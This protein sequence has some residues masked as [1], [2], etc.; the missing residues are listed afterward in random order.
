MRYRFIDIARG[1]AIFLV[2]LGHS[3]PLA[4]CPM[5]KMILG[6]HMPLFFFLSGIFAKCLTFNEILGG[7]K[8]KIQVLLLPH[9]VLSI[10]LVLF[11]GCLWL[12]D[13]NR[14][15]GFNII[16]NLFYWFL[17]V[18]F[19]CSVLFMLLSSILNLEKTLVRLIVV[20]TTA[21]CVYVSV[22][23]L[24]YQNSPVFY[25]IRIIPTAFL[26]YFMGYML[27]NRLLAMKEKHTSKR[28]LSVIVLIAALFVLTQVN[29]PVKMYENE[30]GNY[31]FFLMTSII[32]IWVVIKLSR[33]LVY[34]VL[35]EEMGK[36]SLAIYVW[37]FLVIGFFYRL[38]NALMK[39]LGWEDK[40]ILTAIT[41]GI[42]LSCLCV[43]A[44]FTYE[45]MSFMYGVRWHK[46]K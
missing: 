21:L 43:I 41:F 33:L 14:I 27:K 29:S 13:G 45:K 11:N 46:G 15:A 9:F 8:H 44:K 10:T 32:G 17:P 2:V 1:I 38:T 25:W 22:K 35:L 23:Y 4:N 28:G 3:F 12:A 26:F 24:E 6:F 7:V 16:S 39:Y 36:L 18:L 30:Y 34:S 42:S 40:G 20:T 19:S 5:N 31:L 37:N